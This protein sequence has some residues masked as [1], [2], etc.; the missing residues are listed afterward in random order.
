[1][2][3]QRFIF[4]M[5]DGKVT[6]VKTDGVNQILSDKNFQYL[7]NLT[8]E[9]SD[10]YLWLQTEQ[11]IA[12]PH[13]TVT[14]DKNGRTF[15]QNETLL[16]P[17]HDYIQLTNPKQIFTNLFQNRDSVP[18]KLE[19]LEIDSPLILSPKPTETPGH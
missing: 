4:G 13:I 11:V 14:E 5:F 12:F 2:K 10:K 7:R 8:P 17:I 18:E 19:P 9:D 6:L 1:M 15:V 3:I 16:I